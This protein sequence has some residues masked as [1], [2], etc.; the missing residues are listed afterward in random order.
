MQ[1]DHQYDSMRFVNINFASNSVSVKVHWWQYS[2][3]ESTIAFPSVM[4][5]RGV[6]R[7]VPDYSFP[8]FSH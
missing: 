8:S 7:L 5:I 1:T 2:E 3:N 4:I 6:T